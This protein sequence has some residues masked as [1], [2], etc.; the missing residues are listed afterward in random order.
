VDERVL[1]DDL[2]AVARGIEAVIASTMPARG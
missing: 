2:V 1:V